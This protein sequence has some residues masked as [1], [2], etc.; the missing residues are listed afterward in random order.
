MIPSKLKVENQEL[1]EKEL[2]AFSNELTPSLISDTLENN[3][4]N[5]FKSIDSSAPIN[6]ENNKIKKSKKDGKW[7]AIFNLIGVSLLLLITGLDV[8]LAL[9]S[10]AFD[11]FYG[12]S[13]LFFFSSLILTHFSIKAVKNLKEKHP[14]TEPKSKK[15]Q[16]YKNRYKIVLQTLGL[17]VA[18]T[19]LM[20]I[21]ISEIIL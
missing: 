7:R 8:L 11:G 1:E 4:K 13:L 18:A 17:I 12:V 6:K 21:L 2:L 20:A 3:F 15:N 19:T 9:V 10:I 16:P 5:P 14:K